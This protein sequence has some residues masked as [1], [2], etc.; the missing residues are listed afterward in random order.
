MI[1]RIDRLNK[2]QATTAKIKYGRGIATCET[3]GEIAAIEINYVGK[4]KGVKKLGEGW[5]IAIGKNKMIIW[6]LAQTEFTPELFTYIGSLKLID[7]YIVTW[8]KEKIKGSVE[9]LSKNNWEQ[10]T[11][12][13]QSEAR[14]P[15]EIQTEK[16]IRKKIRKSI[17]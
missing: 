8:Q 1:D 11:G 13:W 17:I 14:K 10:N 2:P 7:C 5:N 3:N 9:N 12:E 4:I 16:Y 6:S 15:E